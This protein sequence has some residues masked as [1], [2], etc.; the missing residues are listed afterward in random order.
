M[1]HTKI[2][3]GSGTLRSLT[4]APTPSG[5]AQQAGIWLRLMPSPKLTAS[6]KEGVYKQESFYIRNK[7]ANVILPSFSFLYTKVDKYEDYGA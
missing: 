4:L 7:Q 5:F 6:L 3:A 1:K 2:S